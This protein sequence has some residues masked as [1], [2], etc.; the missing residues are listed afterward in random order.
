[1]PE[2]LDFTCALTS[3]TSTLWADTFSTNVEVFNLE[4]VPT[5]NKCFTCRLNVVSKCLTSKNHSNHSLKILYTRS[6]AATAR[7][8]ILVRPAEI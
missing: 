6:N 1:M 4:K 3:V 2:F 5:L 8:L 7:P